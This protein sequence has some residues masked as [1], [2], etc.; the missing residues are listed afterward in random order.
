[1][2]QRN[3]TLR[4]C[5]QTGIW[6]AIMVALLLGTAQ[7]WTWPQGW[8]FL[9]IFAIG[10]VWFGTWLL[11][12]DPA[13]LAARLG[14]LNQKGQPWWDKLFLLLFIPAWL[15]WLGLMARDSQVW[16]YSQLPLWLNLAGGLLVIL[17]FAGVMRVFL[18]NSF[19]APVVRVQ[20]ERAQ[21]LID[22]GPYALVRHPMYA[23]ALLYLVG[24]PLLLGSWLGL[25]AVPLI[26]LGL[27]PRAVLEE[28]MLKRDLPG[29]ADYMARVRYR[30]IPG[31][32]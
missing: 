29:Y 9:T 24:T 7:N 15:G 6:L 27:A 12:R 32:W 28:R 3:L 19:A 25:A 14:S 23:G 11:R 31:I 22:T 20:T 16:R 13:L 8:A 10:S 21:K 5:L 26:L 18:E 2:M 1:M 30:L 17:G 4:F